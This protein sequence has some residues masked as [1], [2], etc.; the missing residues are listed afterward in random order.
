M[1]YRLFPF[2]MAAFVTVLLVANT[3]A[4]KV[5]QIGPFYFDG[6]TV[7]F[8]LSYI[9]GDV[10][11]EVYGYKRARLVVW[12]GF[13]ACLLMASLYALVGALP[14]APGWTA[15]SAYERILG[16][17]PRIVGA[18]LVAY[19]CGEFANSFVLA[20][21]K[22]LTRG[23]WLFT[24]TIGSTLVGELVDSALFVALAFAGTVPSSALLRM[25]ASNYSFKTAFEILATPLT[26]AVVGWL[27]RVENEDYYDYKTNFNPFA[28]SWS[29]LR[30]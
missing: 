16:Q 23:R 30:D 13:A 8:P 10:L 25:A 9:F 29:D 7:F 20:K 4:V 21:M 15:Q 5:V 19:F 26:Y 27:K 18:S 28:V 17:A 22:I 6:A 3:V 24:R 11:T 12:T 14:P 2:V 1:R